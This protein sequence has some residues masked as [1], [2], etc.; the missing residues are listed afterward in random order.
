MLDRYSAELLEQP[1]KRGQPLAKDTVWTYVKAVRQLLS[2]AN[3]EGEGIQAN[4]Q[5]PKRPQ[6]LP[7]I[8]SRDEIRRLED[9]AGN[10][11]DALVVRLLADTAI[12]NDELVKLRLALPHPLTPR[13]RELLEEMRRL[14]DARPAK[15]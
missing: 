9:A 1:G 4:A 7:E 14:H 13:D 15:S 5:L 8:L 6:K 2:W 3:K 11:R 12:R 10:E